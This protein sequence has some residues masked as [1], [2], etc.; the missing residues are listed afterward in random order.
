[1]TGLQVDGFGTL[2]DY[3]SSGYIEILEF[4]GDIYDLKE[5]KLYENHRIIVGDQ[6]VVLYKAPFTSWL[7]RSN[8]KHAGW[9][10]RPDNLMAAGPLDNLVG[11]QY[12]VDHLENLKA[13]TFD[14]IAHPVVYL[15]GMVEEFKWG[16]GEQIHGDQESDV[17]VLAPDATALNAN[18]EIATL[19]ALMEEMAGAPKQ[20]MGIRT[21][22]EKTAY[23]VQTLENASGRIFQSKVR[24]FEKTFIEP[25]LNTMLASARQ[26]LDG[27]E[28]IQTTDD[29]LGAQLFKEITKDDL[30]ANGKLRPMGARHFAQ[31]AQMVQNF[32]AL[33]GSQLWLDQGF[34]AHFSGLGIAQAFEELLGFKKYKIVRENIAVVEGLET[35]RMTQ[36]ATDQAAMEGTVATETAGVTEEQLAFIAGQSGTAFGG[37]GGGGY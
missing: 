7:G 20:A 2:S 33:I 16:P 36:A 12:R 24:H 3:F 21:P 1:V 26:N 28:R 25:V 35:Q 10:L 9:R 13:D 31:K 22:G 30:K 15:K 4:E 37:G 34:R 5:G 23:E 8:K 27:V 6:K 32:N 19:L 18:F 17:T 14:Q 29:T 11:M